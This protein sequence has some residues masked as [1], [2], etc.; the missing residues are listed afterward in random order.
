M[1]KKELSSK[2]E[3]ISN[4]EKENNENGEEEVEEK[5]TV[6][7]FGSNPNYSK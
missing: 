7:Q 3:A 4:K 2:S 6:C 5:I 1:N